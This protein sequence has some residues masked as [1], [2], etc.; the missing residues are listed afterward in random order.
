MQ[1]M[2]PISISDAS[3]F[4][5]DSGFPEPLVE[6]AFCTGSGNGAAK[7][8]GRFM[9][10]SD[11]NTGNPGRFEQSGRFMHMAQIRINTG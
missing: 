8:Y 1:Q 2:S 5:S 9:G 4:G 11:Q 10:G 7:V 6:G 3:R